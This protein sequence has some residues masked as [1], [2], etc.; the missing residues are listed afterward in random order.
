MTIVALLTSLL[1]AFPSSPGLDSTKQLSNDEGEIPVVDF[2]GL[3]EYLD[4]YSDK[5]VV[6]NFWATWCA[7]C[8]KELPYFEEV[9]AHY[10]E[11]DVV[12][13][14]VSLDFIKQMDKKLIPFLDKHQL[15]S[16][17]VLLNA[18]DA[19][20]WIDKVSPEW[21][22]AIPATV[23]RKGAESTFYEGSFDSFEEINNIIKQ[24]LNS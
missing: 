10:K 3:Q 18:P 6:I 21:S 8:V 23:V 14:L 4:Q 7:P 22:G 11:D 5:T 2:A 15:K 12:V 24:Y 1:L 19:N 16:K 13:V 20:A 9:T 17:V